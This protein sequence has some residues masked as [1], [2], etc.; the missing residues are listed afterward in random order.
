MKRLLKSKLLWLLVIVLICIGLYISRKTRSTSNTNLGNVTRGDLVQRVSIAGNIHPKRRTVISAPYSGYVRKLYVQVGDQVR[1][2]DPIVSISQSLRG[3]N[4]EVF[5][6]RA[7]FPGTVVQTL[8]T[9]GEYV[10]QNSGNAI[11][12]IDDLTQIMIEANSPEIEVGKLK[13]GQEVIVK[14]SAILG[15]TYKGK[16]QHIALA[17]KEQKDWDKSRVE[18]T[19]IISV[20]DPDDQIKPGM[21]VIIDVI[22][23]KL[24]NVL[25]LR[26]EFIQKD[27]STYFIVTDKGVKKPIQVGVQN[28][29]AFEIK[30]GVNEG[31]A[32]R[33]TDFL[34]II[35]A[36]QY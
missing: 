4:E 25:L 21:S 7:P 32:V 24:S 34:S 12:R 10:D 31:E 8:K 19:V 33:Q 28:E 18:F 26:H 29:E 2:G 27:G 17:A 36:A 1:T 20:L 9:E 35:E 3:T 5:P 22:T 13:L 23:M 30:E 15:R 14:A 16:I 11:V 6:L